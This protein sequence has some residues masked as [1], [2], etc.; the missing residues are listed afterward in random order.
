MVPQNAVK[1]DLWAF[2]GRWQLSRRIENAIG[3]DMR[4]EGEA[5]FSRSEDA[6]LLVE[7]GTLQVAGAQPMQGEQSYLWRQQGAE[8]A[9]FFA[10]GRPFFEFDPTSQCSAGHW[11]S[12]DQY[13]VSL[14]FSR[15]PLWQA[16]WRVK[17]PRKDYLMRSTYQR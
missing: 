9:T 2:E 8:I 3:P 6:L 14:D 5:V 15:W 7:R 4:L 16:V 11:C 12:P 17:G 10:D 13:D 1:L